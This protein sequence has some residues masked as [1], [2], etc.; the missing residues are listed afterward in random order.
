MKEALD[1]VNQHRIFLKNE[2]KEIG[3]QQHHAV[4]KL[5]FTLIHLTYGID[6]IIFI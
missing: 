6:L 4:N 5:S 1:F 3:H 2:F